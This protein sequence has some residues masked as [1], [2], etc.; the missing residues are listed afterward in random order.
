MKG[1][2]KPYGVIALEVVIRHVMF[3]PLI[4]HKRKKREKITIDEI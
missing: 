4:H 3:K 2:A 1:G